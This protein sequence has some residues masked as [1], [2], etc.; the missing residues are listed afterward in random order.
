MLNSLTK[1]LSMICKGTHLLKQCVIDVAIHRSDIFALL[2]LNDFLRLSFSRIVF[3]HKP[4]CFKSE[5][6][7]YSSSFMREVSEFCTQTV[8]ELKNFSSVRWSKLFFSLIV[9]ISIYIFLASSRGY[10]FEE[11]GWKW[12]ICCSSKLSWV[13]YKAA[14]K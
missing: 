12:K 5:N 7:K 11:G 9:F 1:N 2:L 10:I 4:G 14:W 13:T 8:C 6:S 3:I